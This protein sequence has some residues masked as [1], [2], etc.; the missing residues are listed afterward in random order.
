MDLLDGSFDPTFVKWVKTTETALAE[1]QTKKGQLVTDHPAK[2]TVNSIFMI[3][4]LGKAMITPG[5]SPAGDFIRTACGSDYP[6][7]NSKLVEEHMTVPPIATV[8]APYL[9]CTIPEKDLKPISISEMR[10]ETHHWGSKV[11]LHKMS[12]TDRHE[13]VMFIVEDQAGTA[14][15]L[16]L[17]HQPAEMEISCNWTM[18][19]YR[20]CIVKNPFF[21]RVNDTI[22]P[23]FS[24]IP[25]PY[26][27]LRVDHPGD[28]I[29]L[30]HGDGRIPEAWK[31]DPC[32]DD[33]T[34]QGYRD[35]GNKAF[36]KKDWAGAHHSSVTHPPLPQSCLT[37]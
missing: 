25:Q 11:L 26:Y 9:P 34:S 2:D 15:L 12:S 33:K 6:L 14:V 3:R 1:A 31:A 20:V 36:R 21:Q 17:Y 18:M 28:I 35:D 22:S 23:N 10:L 8:E 30:H 7:P 5:L 16:K 24:Q 13:A 32:R 27:S 29:P 4:A 37:L 19:N